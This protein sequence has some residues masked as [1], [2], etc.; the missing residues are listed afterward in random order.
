MHSSL[1][2]NEGQDEMQR[3]SWLV[4]A[5]PLKGTKADFTAWKA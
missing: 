2:K 4:M 1:Y 3:E 5:E